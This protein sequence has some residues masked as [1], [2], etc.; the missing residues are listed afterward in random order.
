MSSCRTTDDRGLLESSPPSVILASRAIDWLLEHLDCFE[1]YQGTDKPIALRQKALT[2]LALLCMCLHS[3]PLFR[4]DPR[5][6]DFLRFLL[7]MY[8]KPHFHERIF[9]ITQSFVSYLAMAVALRRYDLFAD[10]QEWR[11]LQTLLD[12][13]NILFT[14]RTPHG[15]L[16][17]RYLLDLGRLRHTLPPYN[18]LCRSSIVSKPVSVIHITDAEAYSITHA[19]FYLSDFGSHSTAGLTRS[20]RDYVH[21]VVAPRGSLQNRP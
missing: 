20:Q 7:E 14:E 5:V 1:P 18:A 15:M 4:E 12:H 10:D 3:Q 9:A 8:T 19:L 17:L 13:S 2:E 16:E 6:T 21:W 11:T